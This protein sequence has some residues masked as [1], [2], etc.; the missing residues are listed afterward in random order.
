ME[1]AT[2]PPYITASQGRAFGKE[3]PRTKDPNDNPA[4]QASNETDITQKAP[5]NEADKPKGNDQNDPKSATQTPGNEGNMQ[6]T[7]DKP[8]GD[9]EISERPRTPG[10]PDTDILIINEENNNDNEVQ[11]V[12]ANNNKEAQ[13]VPGSDNNEVQEVPANERNDPREKLDDRSKLP[14]TVKVSLKVPGKEKTR[15][16]SSNSSSDRSGYASDGSSYDSKLK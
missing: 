2:E 4:P 9:L 13:E 12:P 15:R 14:G 6:A 10:T 8:P 3:I 7:G 11:E 1:F 5:G 16:R